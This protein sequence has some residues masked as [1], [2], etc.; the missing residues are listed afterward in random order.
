M[1]AGIALAGLLSRQF[2]HLHGH[3][4]RSIP[5]LLVALSL[6][7][8]NTEMRAM[9]AEV[10]Y[11]TRY[12]CAV[13]KNRYTRVLLSHQYLFSALERRLLAGNRGEDLLVWFDPDET[14]NQGDCERPLRDVAVPVL[15]TGFSYLMP[16]SD[17]KTASAVPDQYFD[18]LDPGR[19]VV[20][21]FTRDP[22]NAG[23]LGERLRRRHPAWNMLGSRRI[24]VG[25]SPFSI[26]LFGARTELE[27][28]GY[29]AEL[30]PVQQ[31]N[32]AGWLVV[33]VRVTSGPVG[34][35]L[36]EKSRNAMVT[37]Q[38]INSGGGQLE[39]FLPIRTPSEPVSV[40][41]QTAE[42][43]GRGLIEIE[44]LSFFPDPAMGASKPARSRNND[45]L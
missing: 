12:D 36:I 37:R 18:H 2:A 25:G 28:R 42:R 43:R 21:A 27:K 26:Y 7:T 33:K 19:H 35:G 10:F 41:L 8:A 39:I 5:G 24:D 31:P 1:L 14:L 23:V 9:D 45:S 40:V 17:M 4:A 32:R 34:V 3:L 44:G 15:A 11:T 29:A 16:Y 30:L 13:H 38:L 6:G 20:A 22:G